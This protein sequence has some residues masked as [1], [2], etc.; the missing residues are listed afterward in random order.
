MDVP[1]SINTID[2]RLGYFARRLKLAEDAYNSNGQTKNDLNILLG[3]AREYGKAQHDARNSLNGNGPPS[4][5][6]N[7]DVHWKD[8]KVV[9]PPGLEKA[10]PEMRSHFL[11]SLEQRLSDKGIEFPSDLLKEISIAKKEAESNEGGN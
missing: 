2:K 10:S 4:W 1:S 11:F 6:S 5:A 8:N 7:P 9:W 3:V